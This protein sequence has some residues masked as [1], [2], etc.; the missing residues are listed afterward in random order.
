MNAALV[1]NALP[2]LIV[3]SLYSDKAI[4]LF[5]VYI[6]R[7]LSMS[8]IF[9]KG[10]FTWKFAR[11]FTIRLAGWRDRPFLTRGIRDM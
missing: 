8:R 10:F 6:C 9:K 1:E 7:C 3:N 2:S 4:G 5:I 11:G